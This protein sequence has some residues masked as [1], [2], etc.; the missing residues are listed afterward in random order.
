MKTT[1]KAKRLHIVV[2]GCVS[3]IS[4]LLTYLFSPVFNLFVFFPLVL[5]FVLTLIVANSSNNSLR[6]EYLL[7][8]QLTALALMTASLTDNS[9]FLLSIPTLIGLSTA[10]TMRT[11]FIPLVT[12]FTFSL[13]QQTFLDVSSLTLFA[14]TL[15]S[16][17]CVNYSYN[18]IEAKSASC[19][20]A[21]FICACDRR[22]KLRT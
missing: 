21:S 14:G 12:V 9:I 7:A 22:R 17:S 11:F 1:V 16:V 6:Q 5:W 18:K 4:I 19:H 8:V 3:G 10:Q 2:L 20:K 15:V 13:Y